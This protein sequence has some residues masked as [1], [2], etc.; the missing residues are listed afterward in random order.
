MSGGLT[1]VAPVCSVICLQLVAKYFNAA[2]T[3]A[4]VS[5]YAPVPVSRL[6]LAM[7]YLDI[8]YVGEQSLGIYGCACHTAVG[9]PITCLTR[10]CHACDHFHGRHQPE[11][12]R[13][14]EQT[15]AAQRQQAAA[16]RAAEEAQ[17][18]AYAEARSLHN[19]EKARMMAQFG[20][21]MGDD[22]MPDVGRRAERARRK[23]ELEAADDNVRG[24][25]AARGRTNWARLRAHTQRAAD[26][27]DAGAGGAT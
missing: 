1:R 6:A 5:R 17:A 14:E 11:L 26:H 2:V 12:V 8:M 3:S 21:T 10:A 13:M 15:A 23:A 18:L 7:A 19:A 22:G 25:A 24:A 20:L 9:W 27:V 4:R 16:A